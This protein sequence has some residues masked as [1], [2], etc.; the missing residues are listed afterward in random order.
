MLAAFPVAPAAAQDAESAI[1]AT[2]LPQVP[3]APLITAG[4]P[5]EMCTGKRAKLP[6]ECL[7]AAAPDVNPV[8][9]ATVHD[10]ESAMLITSL[11]HTS[12]APLVAAG[13]AHARGSQ[14]CLAS[15]PAVLETVTL[16][17]MHHVSQTTAHVAE[18][19][20]RSFNCRER[21]RSRWRQ[22]PAPSMR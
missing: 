21:L 2:P 13:N 12:T 15:L 4:S 5:V 6:S 22:M 19:A 17:V 1:S 7:A 16:L 14:I 3:T 18:S 8:A 10:A 11:P 20:S 9:Q